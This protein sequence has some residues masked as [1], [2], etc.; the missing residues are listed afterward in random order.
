VVASADD[1][2]CDRWTPSPDA[3]VL[4]PLGLVQAEAKDFSE[5]AEELSGEYTSSVMTDGVYPSQITKQE[6]LALIREHLVRNI[7]HL[8]TRG[9]GRA[10]DSGGKVFRQVRQGLFASELRLPA[11]AC[12]LECKIFWQTLGWQKKGPCLGH[13]AAHVESLTPPA[14][15]RRAAGERAVGNPVQLLPGRPGATGSPGGSHPP[16][17]PAS[18]PRRVLLRVCLPGWA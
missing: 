1:Q 6:V 5:L 13:S 18:L 2:P 3:D 14:D 11:P 8:P 15:P 9:G 10:Q 16:G 7:V 17:P 4:G 12:S